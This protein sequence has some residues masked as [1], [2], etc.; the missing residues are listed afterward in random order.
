MQ[1]E[2]ILVQGLGEGKTFMAM[3]H[4]KQEIKSKL[5]FSPYE[6]TLNI[7]TSSNVSLQN[8]KVRIAGFNQ[9]EKTFGGATCYRAS[10]KTVQGADWFF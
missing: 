9:N 1:I 6:G 10:I 4:Y 2:G 5:G 8:D 3:P 7:K